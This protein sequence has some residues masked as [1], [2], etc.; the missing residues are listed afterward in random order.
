MRWG[1]MRRV[2]F[3]V[4]MHAN[5]GCNWGWPLVKYLHQSAQLE[6][7]GVVLATPLGAI[8][9]VCAALRLTHV[10]LV[11]APPPPLPN[12]LVCSIMQL[13]LLPAFKRTI[14]LHLHQHPHQPCS[15]PIPH[16][17]TNHP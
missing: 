4:L 17:L 7:V 10:A 2:L 5:W 12:I 8:V 13:P 9:R 16:A 11:L 3:V 15:S 1:G 14:T 6:A